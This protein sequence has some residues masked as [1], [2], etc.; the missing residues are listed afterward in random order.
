MSCRHLVTAFGTLP[1][2]VHAALH[3]ADAL[4]VV[5][6]L[7]ADFRAFAARMLVVLGADQHEVGGS[8]AHLGAGHHEL[9]VGRLDVLASHLQAVPHGHRQALAVAR[10]AV[11]DALLHLGGRVMHHFASFS[12]QAVSSLISLV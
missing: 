11:V 8:P 4:A 7:S 2:G 5:G 6:A 9:E 3:V 10:E 1:A 12:T